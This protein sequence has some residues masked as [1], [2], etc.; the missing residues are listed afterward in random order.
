MDR[1][2][3]ECLEKS[4]VLGQA[5]VP[6]GLGVFV[7]SAALGEGRDLEAFELAHDLVLPRLGQREGL[8]ISRR[9]QAS[10]C[11]QPWEENTKSVLVVPIR[12][13]GRD[14]PM[15]SFSSRPRRQPQIRVKILTFGTV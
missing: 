1:S 15:N 11:Y 6:P 7:V 9:R 13:V 8:L 10:G 14:E 12:P 2:R 4:G 3:L 5:L